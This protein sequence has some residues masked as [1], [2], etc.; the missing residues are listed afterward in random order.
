MNNNLIEIKA[1]NIKKLIYTIRGKQVMLDSDLA[2]LYQVET[3]VL[4]QAVKRNIK[5]F[6][7]KF[8]FR[9]TD[10]EYKVLISQIVISKNAETRGGRQKLPYVF[11]EAGIAM[12]SA[13]LRS[14]IAIDVS[15]KIM[16]AFVEMRRFLVNNKE[17]FSRLDRMELKQLETDQKLEQV[18]NY[19]ATSKVVSQKIF[20]NGQIYDAFS[21]LVDIVKQAD[22]SIILIDN[23]VGLDTLNILAKKKGGVKVDI[24][25]TKKSNLTKNDIK[26][27]NL[28]YHNLAVHQI[29]TFHDRFMILDESSCYHIGASIKD[30]GNKSFAIS[31]IEDKR[32]I[33]DILSR[34]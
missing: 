3:R 15:V 4:N 33:S 1:E 6:P 29:D 5:R 23:Y 12:L 25:T 8:M 10:E 17:L 32:N 22:S 21:L 30:A 9:L 24:Y 34:L 7:E 26:K 31:K 19:I 16:D 27:F 11:S 20:F 28:Q 14:E 13:V 2:M 18:F